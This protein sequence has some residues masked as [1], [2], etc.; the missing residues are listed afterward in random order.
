MAGLEVP[1]HQGAANEELAALGRID[2][3]EVDGAL[4]DQSQ[5]V[6]GYLLLGHDGAVF[7][8]PVGVAVVQL[9]EVR[10]QGSTHSGS[11]LALMRA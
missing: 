7:L 11:I 10:R 6:E 3:A 4:I 8:R 9:D 5:A 2:A 1:F